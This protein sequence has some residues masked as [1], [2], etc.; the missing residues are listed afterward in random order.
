MLYKHCWDAAKTLL[1]YRSFALLFD[2]VEILPVSSI[3]ITI[4]AEYQQELSRF[5][6]FK[7]H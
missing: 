4:L 5:D 2:G 1:G 7:S 6:L 3:A